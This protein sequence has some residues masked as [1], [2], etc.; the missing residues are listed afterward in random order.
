M[1][2]EVNEPGRGGEPLLLE[3]SGVSKHFGGVAALKDVSFTLLP[4]EIHGL[5]ARMV[6]ANRR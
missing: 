4:G 2:D 5:V 1:T 3:L 6:R